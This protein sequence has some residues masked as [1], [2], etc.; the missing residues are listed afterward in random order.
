MCVCVSYLDSRYIVSS[1]EVLR[2]SRGSLYRR[3]HA[4]LVVL[5]DEDTRQLPQSRHVERL[6]DLALIGQEKRQC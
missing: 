5:T 2:A 1:L 3:P 4:K 6:K